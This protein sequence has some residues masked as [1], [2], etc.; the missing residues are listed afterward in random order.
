MA[1]NWGVGKGRGQ[2][3]Q[4]LPGLGGH[5]AGGMGLL[6]HLGFV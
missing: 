1:L 4:G 6:Q 2:R 5:R 3:V